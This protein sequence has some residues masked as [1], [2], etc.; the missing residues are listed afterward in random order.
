MSFSVFEL[1]PELGGLIAGGTLAVSD[2]PLGGSPTGAPTGEILATGA[3][4]EV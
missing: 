4:Y 3:F 2:E 1:T